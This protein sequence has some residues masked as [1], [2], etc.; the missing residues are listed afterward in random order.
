MTGSDFLVSGATSY[1]G[2][3]PPVGHKVVEHTAPTSKARS[4]NDTSI[5]R[6]FTSVVNNDLTSFRFRR[7]NRLVR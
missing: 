6:G 5:G 4:L 2:Y 3:I 1:A 7:F